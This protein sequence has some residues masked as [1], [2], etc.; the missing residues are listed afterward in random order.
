LILAICHTIIIE[1]SEGE[2]DFEYQASSPDELALV[3]FARYCG[4]E[5]MGIDASNIMT[6]HCPKNF[7]KSNIEFR[8]TDIKEKNESAEE[9]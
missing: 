9:F 3:N 5:F 2:G 4:F 6:I 1:E 7:E 8:C